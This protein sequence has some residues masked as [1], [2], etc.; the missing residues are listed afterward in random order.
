MSDEVKRSAVEVIKEGSHQLRG[1]LAEELLHDHEFCKDSEHL[2][3]NHGI[4]QQDNRDVRKAK[5]DDGTAKGKQYIFMVRT[6]VPGGKVS[7]KQFLAHLDLCDQYANETLRVTTRQGFQLHGVLKHDLK[8]AVR[9]LNDTLLTTLAA[10][11][12]VERNVM[13]CPAPIKNDLVHD[14]MQ[15]MAD[16][17]AAHLKPRTTA[18]HEIWLTDEAGE[19]TNV[20][21]GFAP[22]DEPIY[23][24]VY[25]P[26]KFKT[27]IA[28]PEDNCIDIYTQDLGFLAI[29]EPD[30]AGTR[31]I[32]GYNV[33]V[34]GGQGKTPSAEKTFVAIAQKLAFV[35]PDQVVKVAEAIVKVQR[36]FGNREDRKVA[37]LKY[38][39]HNHGL[40]WFK[41]KVEEYFVQ[42]LPGPRDIDVTDVDDHIGWHEQGDGK[43]FLGINI[44]C[45]RI[46][47]EGSL[48]IKSGLRAI[49]TK[50]GMETR[51][52]AL[53]AVLLCNIDPQD[54]ADIIALLADH[55]IKQ[56]HELTLLRRY[57]IACP[58]FPTC[59]LS[60]TEAERALPSIIDE[61][62]VEMA[63]LGIK[64]DR[65]SVHMTGCPNGCARPYT[66]DIGLVGKQAGVGG[67]LG[68]YTVYLGGNAQGT[69]LAFIYKDSV[70]QAD[71][72][73]T[74]VAPLQHYK[75]NRLPGEAFGD[76]CHRKG[77]ADLQQHAT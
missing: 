8:T 69:R 22:V 44:E 46:K 34:G 68:K 55:G 62:E 63:K 77:L 18:Y 21:T 66:P 53:Q 28:L 13:C 70:P 76:F 29:V 11:G 27:A 64:G 37:R 58:A 54:K 1:T 40:D 74:L 42:S 17:I 9:G 60:I 33:L 67:A 10:C 5:N 65:I 73:A 31:Q 20:A 3:K 38:T 49:L 52:T 6:R 15:A 45:G 75:A 30:A 50:Y 51:L 71:I 43:L 72:A 7:A 4:Y 59:G 56:D 12:D 24:T 61:L 19:K 14:Q 35:T 25:L 48:R 16:A 41:A 36:D 23:G 26:R 39:I 47:D 32:V 57:S 2:I